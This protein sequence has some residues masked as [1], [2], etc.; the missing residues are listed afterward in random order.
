LAHAQGRL[1]ENLREEFDRAINAPKQT[2]DNL[3]A[4]I[5][6]MIPWLQ[7]M[8]EQGRPN[9]PSAGAA[10]GGGQKV[11]TFNRQTGRLE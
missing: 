1:P 10:Q 6:T 5:N 11:L 7:K 2:P 3:K 8:Q 9:T 4:T